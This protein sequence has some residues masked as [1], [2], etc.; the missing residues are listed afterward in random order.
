MK[1]P[2]RLLSKMAATAGCLTAFTMSAAE[3]APKA[4][5]VPEKKPVVIRCKADPFHLQLQALQTRKVKYVNV[6]G[7]RVSLKKL[8]TSKMS[9]KE[10][11]K[12]RAAVAAAY[13]ASTPKAKQQPNPIRIQHV[14]HC[15]G[16]G[17]G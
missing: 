4:Q 8:D 9:T 11:D 14:D 17:R 10:K 3:V 7:K 5:P 2:P 12:L 13:A 1:I 6:D 15:P 16:C